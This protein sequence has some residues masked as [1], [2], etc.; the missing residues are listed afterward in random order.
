VVEAY[1]D[2]MG[3]DCEDGLVT[4]AAGGFIWMRWS[5]L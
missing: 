3:V 4:S 5:A 1:Y 2:D